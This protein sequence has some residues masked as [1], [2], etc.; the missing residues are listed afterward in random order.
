GRSGQPQIL[1]RRG[2]TD[3]AD[4][5]VFGSLSAHAR[6]PQ[7]MEERQKRR[8]WRQHSGAFVMLITSQAANALS[9]ATLVGLRDKIAS[10][11]GLQPSPLNAGPDLVV[12]QFDR[13]DVPARFNAPRHFSS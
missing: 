2:L 12:S 11:P 6:C 3:S 5:R 4:A 7:P 13:R 8:V 10:T 1:E 9:R